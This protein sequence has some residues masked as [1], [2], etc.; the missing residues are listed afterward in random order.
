MA[1]GEGKSCIRERQ[2]KEGGPETG[3]CPVILCQYG[4]NVRG[5][6]STK[7]QN[8]TTPRYTGEILNE[9]VS[10]LEGLE[11]CS[12]LEKFLNFIPTDFFIFARFISWALVLFQQTVL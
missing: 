11:N 1:I 5:D 2:E 3:W 8:L 7:Q 10:V 4:R 6:A 9:I 12:H